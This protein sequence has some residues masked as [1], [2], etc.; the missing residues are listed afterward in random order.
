MTRTLPPLVIIGG[1]TGVGKSDAAVTLAKRIGGE[2]ISADS[3]QVYR[4]MDIGTAKLTKEEMDGVPHHMIDV[5]DP[6]EAF[7]I[8]RFTSMTTE[9][10]R[11]VASRGH[12]PMLVGGT[13]FYIRAVLYGT[14]FSEEDDDPSIRLELEKKAREEGGLKL[15]EYL[16]QIDPASAAAIPPG[17]VKRVIRAIEYYRKTGELISVHNERERAKE[18]VYRFAYFALTCDR[19][20]MYERIDRR[21]DRMAEMGLVGEV[22]ALAEQG[23][24]KHSVSMQGLGYRQILDYLDGQATL[25]EALSKIKQETRHF[26]KRQLTW[27]RREKDVIWLDKEQLDDEQIIDEMIRILIQKGIIPE[28][29]DKEWT[30]QS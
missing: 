15:H 3:M 6:S 17:N 27:L 19:S 10:I 16:E 30:D 25:E 7:N 24:D 14:Q 29:K 22:A 20:H 21:V 2:I 9:C 4:G 26:A 28:G 5:L 1:P 8:A 13:G 18:A 12:I 23:L 11:Q